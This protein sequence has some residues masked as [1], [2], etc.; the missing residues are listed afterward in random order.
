M[1]DRAV[2]PLFAPRDFHIPAEVAHLCAGGEA[3]FLRS[4]DAAMRNYG[5]DKSAGMPGRKAQEAV[6]LRARTLAASLLRVEPADV[7]FVSNV[8]EGVSIL[9]HSIDWRPGDNVCFDA[10]EYPSVVMPFVR[11][12]ESHGV[13]IRLADARNPMAALVDGRTRLIGTS[14]VSYLD[15]SR[16]DLP[17]LRRLADDSGA[18]LLVDYT[19]SAGVLPIQAGIADFAFSA[20]YKW[21]LGTTGLALAYWNRAR[22]PDWQPATA[23]WYSIDVRE[24]RPDYAGPVALRADALRFTRGNPAFIPIYVLANA[25]DYLSRFSMEFIA[26]HVA[27]LTS[28]MFDGLDALGLESITP[29]AAAGRGASVCLEAADAIALVDALAQR[30]V[31]AWGGRGRVR[32][33]FHGYNGSDDV[34]A[35]LS[36]L[37]DLRPGVQ[38]P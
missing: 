13:E 32:F 38:R 8:A 37:R 2:A 30:G 28:R 31:L 7:G 12:V 29:R 6:A 10:N 4:H 34:D 25:L 16:I 36:A 14:H 23:G 17:S 9:A 20:C 21:A 26:D 19:Q 33:S 27:A 35:A 3:A 15:S 18:C 24:G 1:K 5:R 11:S 22:Q